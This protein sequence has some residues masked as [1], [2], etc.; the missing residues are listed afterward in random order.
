MY[1]NQW[2]SNISE[3]LRQH[4]KNNN[5]ITPEWIQNDVQNI[6]KTILG[7]LRTQKHQMTYN[8]M[9]NT[10]WSQQ[11]SAKSVQTKLEPLFGPL[12]SFFYIL[13]ASTPE[14]K[15]KRYTVLKNRRSAPFWKNRNWHFLNIEPTIFKTNCNRIR[16]ERDF[17]KRCREW[18]A[19]RQPRN[20][21]PPFQSL[22]VDTFGTR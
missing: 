14:A 9:R 6:P 3:H 12:I 16:L 5:E 2:N 4:I 17:E 20:S 21:L 1:E 19:K 10:K 13:Q 11:N 18:C 22:F 15:L 8:S 7:V